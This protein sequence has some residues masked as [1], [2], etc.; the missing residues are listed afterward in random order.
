MLHYFICWSDVFGRGR[1]IYT[2]KNVCQEDQEVFLGD[3]TEKIFLNAN[4]QKDDVSPELKA[5]LDYVAG[6]KSDDLFVKKLDQAVE[7]AKTNREWRREYM[8][9][10][11]RD[12]ENIEKGEDKLSVLIA[13][14]IKDKRTDDV[15]KVTQDKEY[16]QKLY[17]EYHVE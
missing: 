3:G 2:F 7:Q 11:M 9:L 5:F 8:T 14:L 16:R 12:Q 15:L 6:R 4:G 13:K 10:L 1:H 17:R